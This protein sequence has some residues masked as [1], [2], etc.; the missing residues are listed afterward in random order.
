MILWDGIGLAEWGLDRSI[1]LDWI[2]MDRILLDF[3]G[4]DLIGLDRYGLDW[5]GLDWIGIVMSFVG[6]GCREIIG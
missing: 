5:I 2:G 4:F 3:I 6:S 1:G